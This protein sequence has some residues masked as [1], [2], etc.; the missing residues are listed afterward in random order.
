MNIRDFYKD[1]YMRA[2]C[3]KEFMDTDGKCR[4]INFYTII[5]IHM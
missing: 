2:A 4:L 3:I 5:Q 1:P